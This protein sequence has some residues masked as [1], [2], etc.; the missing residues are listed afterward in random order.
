[1]KRSADSS[2]G[3]EDVARH[4]VN[5]INIK[6]LKST[7]G[8]IHILSQCIF[9]HVLV[10]L[11]CQWPSFVDIPSWPRTNS[12]CPIRQFPYDSFRG[13]DVTEE[14]A[15]V[16]QCALQQGVVGGCDAV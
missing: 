10:P 8:H 11:K 5:A 2:V 13:P 16:R 4:N 15:R 14:E 1:M 12:L 9:K 7:L 6:T 3:I